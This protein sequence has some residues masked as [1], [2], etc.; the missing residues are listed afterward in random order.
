M[1]NSV[2]KAPKE[3]QTTRS[4]SNMFKNNFHRS[5]R[6]AV[7]TNKGV[8]GAVTLANKGVAWR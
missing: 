1:K 6:G 5:R 8:G 7:L 2:K 3:L 4:S